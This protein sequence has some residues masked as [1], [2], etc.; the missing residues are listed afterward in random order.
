[1]WRKEDGNPQGPEVSSGAAN[2]TAGKPVASSSQGV[3]GKAPACV[4]QGIKIKGELTGSEDLF[5]DGTVDGKVT[6]TSSTLTVGPNAVVRA[7]IVAKELVIRGRAEGKFTASERVQIWS[8]ARVQGD[9][10]SE[11]ISI[12]EGAQMQ[13]KLEAGKP[14]MGANG[15]TSQQNRKSAE[16]SKS[17]ETHLGGEKATSGAASAGAD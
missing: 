14:G 11:R 5:I 10:K 15:E 16:S 4:S 3:S 13:G 2:S 9:I 12:E 17:K 7:E 6:L 8:S 1:M